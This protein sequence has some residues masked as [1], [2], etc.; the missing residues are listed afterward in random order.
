MQQAGVLPLVETSIGK[1]VL[2]A[3]TGAILFGFAAAHAAGNL[4]VFLGAEV[5]N[6]YG[7]TLH[8]MPAV[9]WGTRI[10]LLAAVVIHIALTLSIASRG[11]AARKSR[12]KRPGDIAEESVLSRYA[13]QT[14]ILSGPILAGYL[15]FHL[16]HLT[17]GVV[18]PLYYEYGDVYGNVIYGFRNPIVAGFYIFSNLLLGLHLFHGGR[19]LFQSLGLRHPQWDVR[20]NTAALLLAGFITASNVAIPL[21]IVS[22]VVG[23]ELPD[24]VDAYRAQR[25]EAALAE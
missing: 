10:V 24:S 2:V 3:V 17:G 13:R 14:M 6:H 25:A 4:Q 19:A 16:A 21:S 12:Y 8:S 11:R 5:L 20:T 18:S 9:L 23:G 15:V 7:E 22:R 1:K